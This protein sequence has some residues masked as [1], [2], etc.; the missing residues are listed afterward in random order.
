M[1]PFHTLLLS[2]VVALPAT[3]S[4]S[5]GYFRQPAVHGDTVVF[6]AEGDMWSVPIAGGRAIRLTTHP[7][8]EGRPAISPDGRYLAYTARYEG[9]TEV[10]VMPLA[11]G[12]PRRLTF[13]AATISHVGWTP[14]GKVLVGTNAY[15]GLPAQQLVALDFSA[16]DGGVTR[17][18]VPLAQA[19][20]GC[21][22]E[23]GK[24][25]FFTRLAFQGSH[26]R[27]YK[28]GTAQQLWSFRDGEP[29][30]RPLTADYA[31][32][33][34]SPMPWNG[35]VYFASDRNGTM[36][37]W[38]I[39]PDGSDPQQ[40]TRHSD[41]DLASPVLDGGRIVYQFGADLR[42][43]D[44]AAG[45]DR[46]IPI[47][48]DSDFDHT[49]EKWVKDPITFLSDAHPSPD[50]KSVVV[51]ARG[52]V[53][54]IPRKGGRLVEV[55]R[56]PGV[57]FRDARF[58]PDGKSLVF[59][60]DESG[61]VEVWTAPANGLGEAT[62]LTSDGSVLRRKAVPSPDGKYV[63]H[64]DKN[65][66]L[67]LL[68]VQ[69][70]ENKQLAES[71]VDEF[72]ELAWSP[73]SKWLAFSEAGSNLF[74]RVMLYGVADGKVTP[75]TTDRFD[76]HSPAFS[77]DGKWLYLLSDRNLKSLAP[78]PWGMYQPEPFFDKK[79]KIFHI[80]LV[81]G[82][83]SPFVAPNE[84]DVPDK[85]ESKA[86]GF[87]KPDDEKE[88]SKVP[89]AVTVELDGIAARLI[90]VPV[91]PGNYRNLA[92]SEKALFWLSNQAG[93]QREA[94]VQTVA[95]G[96][97][98]PEVKTVAEKV[99]GY[100]LSADGKKLLLVRPKELHLA[101]AGPETADPKKTQV[102]L[103]AWSF[104]VQPREEWRQMFND[105]WRLERDYFYDRGMHGQ[106]WPA[107]RKKYEPLLERVTDRDELDDLIGA[108]VSELAALHTFVVAGDARKGPDEVTPGR[109][110]ATLT[111]DPQAGGYRVERI[112]RHDPD[113]PDSASPLARP[114]VNVAAG[115][116]IVS[117]D[118][119]PVL[120][121]ADVGELLRGK[122]GREVVLGL[123]P[124]KGES[125]KVVVKPLKPDQEDDLRY[126]EWEYTRRLAVDD[127]GGGDIGYVHL[128]AMTSPDFTAWAKG[129]YPAFTKG[130]LIIDV[131]N[132]RGGNIDSWI[133]GRLLRKAWFYWNQR[134][135]R[136]SLWNMQYAFRG[137]VVVLCNERTASDGEAFSEGIKR[138]K[139]GTLIGTRTW[140]GE[141]WLTSSNGLV[142][143]G[144]ATA[145]EFG[146][147]DREGAWLIEGHG[148]EPDVVVDN[149]PH[150][151][152]NGDDQQLKAAVKLLK[153]K[154][155]E[156]P[157][158]LPP[159][160]PFPKK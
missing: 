32:T 2:A 19:A 102:D 158:T 37:L 23:D 51:T 58:L 10:Y 94:S 36:N 69:T 78:S 6:V 65:F 150:A 101:D 62:R 119:S 28:G 83:R 77:P 93:E 92:V 122:A 90:P 145:A 43:Y 115:D 160:P 121:A 66:R 42:V 149:L 31:G 80:P 54:V 53:F 134:V 156:Q 110:G 146:V 116:V 142:D 97:E 71:P 26:T 81:S 114:G 144:M 88:K 35:R 40:H 67:F 5:P 30:A 33:S 154:L 70:K 148:V 153:Q 112:Y 129:F 17:H 49:R 99:T 141:I 44:V 68:N 140:G 111:R 123:K 56:K 38:S 22:S 98:E 106:D 113:E 25:L 155:K 50:G 130:G 105:A 117:V 139:L 7:G 132:N 29:D 104:S 103:S 24:K 109:L 157:V 46:E 108:M 136:S 135:G 151:T 91:P 120:A 76:S 57:R 63:A 1:L 86:A 60:S 21:Y 73:D 27:R 96:H 84:F 100:E 47:T 138:L 124:A 34:K 128:R 59:F 131:R 72:D 8:A 127:L 11:G 147:F 87:K 152:F 143:K 64:T 89:P 133:I 159:V 85:D 48:L 12:K 125:R 15:A 74:R 137:H 75:V 4:G 14:D 55:G 18:R 79:S 13:D 95:I 107:V 82:L 61:E 9:P 52:R 16:A 126:D 39:M 3:G 20:D 41:F 118:G 45:T